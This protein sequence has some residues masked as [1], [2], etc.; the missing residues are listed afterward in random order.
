MDTM[1]KILTV[2]VLVGLLALA[3]SASAQLAIDLT[4]VPGAPTGYRTYDIMATTTTNLGAMEMVLDASAPG[5]IYHTPS[6]AV[7]EGGTYDTYLSMGGLNWDVLDWAVDVPAATGPEVWTDQ[8]LNKMWA[9]QFG[10][11]SIAGTFQVGRITLANW[12]S[13]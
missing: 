11:H 8:N 9:P 13:A 4:P 10:Q 7:T 1:K 6:P 5:S 12:A 2:S 3:S